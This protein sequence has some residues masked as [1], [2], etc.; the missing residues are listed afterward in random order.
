MLHVFGFG[1]VGVAVG[2]LYFVDPHPG[3]GQEGA[4]RGVRLEVRLLASPPTEGSIYA[5]RPIVVDQ[6][7]WRADLLESVAG[8]PGTWD[9]THHHPKMRG[10]E[11][12][13]RQFDDAMSSDPLGFVGEQLSDL[14]GL[15]LGAGVDPGDRADEDARALRAAVP[16]I[17]E[18]VGALLAGVRDGQLAKGPDAREQAESVRAGWL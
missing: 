15:M 9:R 6:P 18:T 8:G 4:E 7:I 10:W 14:Q 3:V 17:L 2:D 13:S 12:G 11:P 16:E 5:S 1:S